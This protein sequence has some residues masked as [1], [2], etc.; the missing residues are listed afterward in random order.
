MWLAPN[1]V[2][3]SGRAGQLLRCTWNSRSIADSSGETYRPHMVAVHEAVADSQQ[4]SLSSAKLTEACAKSIS[5]TGTG[6]LR[7]D[8]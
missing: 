2:S 3:S 4:T 6:A 1:G 7:S 5:G 8:S